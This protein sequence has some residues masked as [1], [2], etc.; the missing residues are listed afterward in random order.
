MA[1]DMGFDKHTSCSPYVGTNLGARRFFDCPLV[2]NPL[3]RPHAANRHDRGS[4]RAGIDRLRSQALAG[5]PSLV[6]YVATHQSVQFWRHPRRPV[7]ELMIAG[8]VQF[9]SH[10]PPAIVRW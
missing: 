9:L 5:R 8:I 6:H 7:S 4:N 2:T 3:Q 1:I 10:C